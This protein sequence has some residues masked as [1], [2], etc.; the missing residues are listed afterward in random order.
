MKCDSCGYE[1]P[2]D[3]AVEDT[4]NV[5][6]GPPAPWGQ[7][8]QIVRVTLCARCSESREQTKAMIFWPVV[9]FGAI[10]ALGILKTILDYLAPP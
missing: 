6:T 3:E 9:I 1:F 5:P 4:R 7:Q 8:T 2:P 10:V